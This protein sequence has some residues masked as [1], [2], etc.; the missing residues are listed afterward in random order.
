MLCHSAS[1]K[2]GL[3]TVVLIERDDLLSAWVNVGYITFE[4]LIVVWIVDDDLGKALV[5]GVSDEV[6]SAVSLFINLSRCLSCLLYTS[7]SPRDT[8]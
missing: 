8:R 1:V 5:V 6:D 7:P 4:L 2:E 3:L